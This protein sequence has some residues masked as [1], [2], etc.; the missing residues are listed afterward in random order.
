MD[1]RY[2][3]KSCY[4][5][6]KKQKRT[7]NVYFDKCITSCDNKYDYKK[8]IDIYLHHK[9]I[10]VLIE[11]IIVDTGIE[12]LYHKT[13]IDSVFNVDEMKEILR[14]HGEIKIDTWIDYGKELTGGLDNQMTQ[15]YD[16]I[17]LILKGKHI[18]EVINDVVLRIKDSKYCFQ[19]G[20]GHTIHA[21]HLNLPHH[22]VVRPEFYDIV[23]F[24]PIEKLALFIKKEKI[25]IDEVASVQIWGN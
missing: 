15:Y 6:H 19:G 21:Y 8:E 13:I 10:I 17:M 18:E 3:Q 11:K 14:T 22:W 2:F 23:K 24:D 20:K 1:V 7:N 25:E 5:P 16:K 4:N 9:Q 12:N